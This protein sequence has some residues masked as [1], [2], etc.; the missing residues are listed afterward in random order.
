MLFA[1]KPKQKE[2]SELKKILSTESGRK[3]KNSGLELMYSTSPGLWHLLTSLLGNLAL[4]G[5]MVAMK[6]TDKC[7]SHPHY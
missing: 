1:E 7:S 5:S 4:A 2:Q 3:L 6:A